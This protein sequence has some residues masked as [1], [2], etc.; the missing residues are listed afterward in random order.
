ME[1]RVNALRCDSNDCQ[2]LN[3]GSTLTSAALSANRAAIR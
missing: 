1:T 3:S 2:V